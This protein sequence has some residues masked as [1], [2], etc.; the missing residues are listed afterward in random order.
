M[1]SSR[2]RFPSIERDLTNYE[3]QKAWEQPLF[4]NVLELFKVLS[5]E[6]KDRIVLSLWKLTWNWLVFSKLTF[7]VLLSAR[8]MFNHF[9]AKSYLNSSGL[10]RK[11]SETWPWW[12]FFAKIVNP[13]SAKP[14]KS[15]NNSS[16]A[17]HKLFECV[18]PFCGVD[19]ERV[20]D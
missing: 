5:G 11:L 7:S 15:S 6:T 10:L 18:W 13:L 20:N 12:N 16:T 4:Q 1:N 19:A 3:L 9:V 17:A 8:L 14:T 2:G